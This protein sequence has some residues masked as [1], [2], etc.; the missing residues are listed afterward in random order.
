M[1]KTLVFSL[2]VL[3]ALT[4]CYQTIPIFYPVERP[5]VEE[6]EP[7]TSW[8]DDTKATEYKVNSVGDIRGL[9]D[10]VRAGVE[11]EGK[12]IELQ[13]GTYDFSDMPGFQVG[14]GNRYSGTETPDENTHVFRGEFDGNGAVIS[15]LVINGGGIGSEDDG[16]YGFFG[17]VEDANIHD[18]VFENCHVTSSASSTGIAVGYA[19]DSSFSNIMVRNSTV[20][21]SESAGAIVGRMYTSDEAATYTIENNQVINTSVVVDG[22]FHAGGIIGY[23]NAGSASTIVLRNNTVDL[24][25]GATITSRNADGLATAGAIAGSIAGKYDGT[26]TTAAVEFVD[27][28]IILNDSTQISASGNSYFRGYLFGYYTAQLD[29]GERLVIEASE[30]NTLTLN[31]TTTTIVSPKAD[32][33]AE[34]TTYNIIEAVYTP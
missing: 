26:T 1:R 33:V 12:K 17:L 23:A 10:L 21:G 27:N 30:N 13:P 32:P 7:D 8:F 16:A 24:T 2:V 6:T 15:G 20:Q 31:G 22:S 11:F 34:G 4:S 29:L 14:S 5:T 28:T 18:L 3:F 25:G 9:A 19:Y